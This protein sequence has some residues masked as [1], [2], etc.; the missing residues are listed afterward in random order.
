M[1]ISAKHD[2]ADE[3]PYLGGMDVVEE[4]FGL[5]SRLETD[6]QYHER[7]LFEQKRTARRLQKKID[8]LAIKR[9]KEFAAAVQT[10]IVISEEVRRSK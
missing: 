1:Y 7:D 6:R 8:D 5:I 10:G 3:L 4:V 2:I 9:A